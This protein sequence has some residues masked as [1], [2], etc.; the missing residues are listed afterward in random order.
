MTGKAKLGGEPVLRVPNCEMKKRST[1][2]KE[3]IASSPDAHRHRLLLRCPATGPVVSVSPIGP[4]L[5]SKS[6]RMLPRAR[7]HREQS[8]DGGIGNAMN[9]RDRDLGMHRAITRRDFLNGAERRPHRQPALPVG[10]LERLGAHGRLLPAGAHRTA[11]QPSRLLRGG[12][13]PARRQALARIGGRG[14]GRDVR[15]RRRRRGTERPLRRPGSIVRRRVPRLASSSSTITTTSAA[16]RSAT[17]FTT[18]TACSSATEARST[19]RTTTNTAAR[20]GGCSGSSG[21]T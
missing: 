10:A 16:T 4:G 12:A 9:R 8:L 18:G 14:L 21:S 19:S 17:S 1:A 11:R 20:R 15:P 6:G 7:A 3:K 5:S 13:F 2:W